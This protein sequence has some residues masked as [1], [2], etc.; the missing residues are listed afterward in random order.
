MKYNDYYTLLRLIR[1]FNEYC[2]EGHE[3]A[4]DKDPEDQ[5]AYDVWDVLRALVYTAEV[6]TQNQAIPLRGDSAL[7]FPRLME[8]FIDSLADNN[9][10]KTP[11][12]VGD[13]YFEMKKAIGKI[14]RTADKIKDAEYLKR[15]Y[16]IIDGL[17]K[18]FG[19]DPKKSLENFTDLFIMQELMSRSIQYIECYC[20]TVTT[21][22]GKEKVIV[23][24]KVDETSAPSVKRKND[25]IDLS[26][27]DK[28]RFINYFKPS[29][30]GIGSNSG[31]IPPI[32]FFIDHLKTESVNYTKTDLGRVAYLIF[33]SKYF[34]KKN[35][36][37]FE[38]W[39]RSFFD[40]C[41]V[42]R[43]RETG[44]S[45]YSNTKNVKSLAIF[46]E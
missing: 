18:K 37:S 17:E 27:F 28:D 43:P 13:I 23:S 25:G 3:W 10:I 46:L 38:R 35:N 33:E 36:T 1:Y 2:E 22:H 31:C 45:K 29:F 15:L 20:P 34:K 19:Q 42:E 24:E 14:N 4:S 11:P 32:N 16:P 30:I 41:G 44:K 7:A 9:G 12:I 8:T 39:L 21:V 40:I 6:I 26:N 5:E